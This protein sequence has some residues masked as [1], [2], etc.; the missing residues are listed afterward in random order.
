MAV[1]AQFQPTVGF[2]GSLDSEEFACSAGDL[3]LIP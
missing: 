2:P 3:S 1:V